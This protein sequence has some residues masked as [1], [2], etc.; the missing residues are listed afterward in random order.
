[1]KKISG[2]SGLPDIAITGTALLALVLFKIPHL[3]L[4]CFWDEAWSYLPAILKMAETTPSLLPDPSA[5]DLFRGHPLLFYAAAA[6]WIKIFGH[7][8]VAMRIFPLLVSMGLLVVFYLFSKRYFGRKIA[9]ISMLFLLIQAVF[10]AQSSMLLPETGLALLNLLAIGA[11]LSGKRGAYVIWSILLVLT[12]ESGLVLPLACLALHFAEPLWNRGKHFGTSLIPRSGYLWI[13][14]LVA[15]SFLI[16]QK[17][18]M[19]WFFFPEHIGLLRFSITSVIQRLGGYASFLFI[20]FGRNLLT[21]TAAASLIYLVIRKARFSS[22]E[23]RVII[24]LTAFLAAY[25]LFLSLNF[26]SP[27]YLLSILPAFLLLCLVLISKATA[28]W[29][30]AGYFILF[31]VTGNNLWFT[32][33]RR[34]D[35]D[36]NL[37]FADAVEVHRQAVLYCDQQNWQDRPLAT[38]FLMRYYLEHPSAGYV[39]AGREF[40]NVSP[41]IS[42]STQVA[43]ISSTEFTKDFQARIDSS[44][45]LPV[46]RF[47]KRNAWAVIY[48]KPR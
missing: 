16:V 40:L 35:S 23:I 20:G 26:Y 36:H 3:S 43:V 32:L 41:G 25:L 4:P 22:E 9:V 7:S 47:E 21:L 39:T 5:T 29:P 18:V 12:K 10:L 8:F 46:R 24:P 19:G 2:N 45:F 27:R 1:M 11:F 14:L 48:G 34:T 31:V 6:L 44:H 17:A 42:D 13:P 37:G 30:V 15:G 33:D 38:H 28:Q